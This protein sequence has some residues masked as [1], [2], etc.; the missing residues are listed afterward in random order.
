MLET[1]KKPFLWMGVQWRKFESWCA[2]IFPGAK[3]KTIAVLGALGNAAYAAK[4][5]VSGLPLEKIA[6]AE[7][8]LVM[9]IVLFTLAFWFRG[10]ANSDDVA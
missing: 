4:D 3:T 6:T 10:M 8:V 9:N 2:E 5:Y 1:I 7:T